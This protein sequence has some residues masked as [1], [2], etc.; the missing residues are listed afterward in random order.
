MGN[1]PSVLRSNKP[2]IRDE[3]KREVARPSDVQDHSKKEIEHN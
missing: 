2:E 3:Q 1:Q